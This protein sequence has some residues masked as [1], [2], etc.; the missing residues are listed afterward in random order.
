MRHVKANVKI[1]ISMTCTLDRPKTPWDLEGQI[2]IKIWENVCTYLTCG[3]PPTKPG[4]CTV[5]LLGACDTCDARDAH[6]WRSW[7]SL[8]T[9]VTPDAV[10]YI[11]IIISRNV[12]D[13][14]SLAWC[15]LLTAKARQKAISMTCTLDSQG[16]APWGLGLGAWLYKSHPPP[17]QQAVLFLLS[18]WEDP[19]DY[20]KGSNCQS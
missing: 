19:Q 4:T 11:L 6:L 18:L 17:A 16:Q 15:V 12:G 13:K 10:I 2:Q 9:L 5:G 20:S 14:K 1:A 3:M 8:V 7:R